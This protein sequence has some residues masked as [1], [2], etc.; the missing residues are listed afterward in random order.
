MGRP[1]KLTPEVQATIVQV[2]EEGNYFETAAAIAGISKVTLYSWI[3]KG[4]AGDEPFA[5]FLNALKDAEAKAERQAL[6]DVRLGQPG[7]QANMTFLE[8]RHPSRWSRRDPDHGVKTKLLEA[9]LET[10]KQKLEL[11]K[12]GIN[13][14]GEQLVV[15]RR[16]WKQEPSG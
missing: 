14:D 8:R 4:E 15:I 7:W 2:V 3:E 13:P 12:A 6:A 16:A 9:E 11:L 1:T 10:A 5:E